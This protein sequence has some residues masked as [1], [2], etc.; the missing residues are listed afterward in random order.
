MSSNDKKSSKPNVENSL[1]ENLNYDQDDLI[2]YGVNILDEKEFSM[3]IKKIEFLC[4]KSQEY[5]VWSKKTKQEAR[6]QNINPDNDDSNN[7]PIC[8]INYEYADPES[9]HHPMTLFNICVRQF[10]KWVDNNELEDKTPLDLVQEIMGD[11]LINRV[12]HVVLCKHCHEKYHNGE[13]NIKKQLDNIIEYKR[14]LYKQT[15]SDKSREFY[16]NINSARNEEKNQRI[17]RKQEVF[18]TPR[19]LNIDEDKI[20]NELLEFVNNTNINW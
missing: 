10:Q 14:E 17:K 1:L 7:C 8:G 15:L 18:V 20:K 13:V 12:E 6:L 19:T 5:T 11:H 2:F 9:H 16:E 3:F 4:R